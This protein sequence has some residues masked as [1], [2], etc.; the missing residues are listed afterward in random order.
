MFYINVPLIIQMDRKLRQKQL[1]ISY[2][3]KS[4]F[5][6]LAVWSRTKYNSDWQ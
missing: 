2:N 3:Q 5:K 4:K 1:I 6:I